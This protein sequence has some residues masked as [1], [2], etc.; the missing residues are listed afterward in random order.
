MEQITQTQKLQRRMRTERGQEPEPDQNVTIRRKGHLIPLGMSTGL[1][2]NGSLEQSG[3]NHELEVGVRITGTAKVHDIEF[4][5]ANAAIAKDKVTAVQ[6]ERNVLL[7]S[8]QE[9]KAK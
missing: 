1:V 9:E 5:K 6:E 8:I 2:K 7:T 3:G 4:S